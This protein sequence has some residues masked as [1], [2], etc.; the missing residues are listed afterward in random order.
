MIAIMRGMEVGLTP[1]MALDKIAIVNGRPTIWGDGALG[2]VR[3]SG[4][5]EYVKET[6]EGEGDNLVAICKAK[7]KGEE[8]EITRTFSVADA[9]KAKLWGKQGPWQ[10]YS[11]RMLSMRARAFALRDLFADVLGGLYLK[12]EIDNDGAISPVA[13]LSPPAPPSPPAAPETPP[14]PPSAPEPKEEEFMS[15][16]DFDAFVKD[17]DQ[18]LAECIQARDTDAM[19]AVWMTM[20]EPETPHLTN[21]QYEHLQVLYNKAENALDL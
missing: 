14:S 15:T 11:R 17:F 16:S 18:R 8:E 6:F 12:E 7:R 9:K 20:V 13:A 19:E 3:A 2:L 10:D 21:G 4:L 5:C 1:M